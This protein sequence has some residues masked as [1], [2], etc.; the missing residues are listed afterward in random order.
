MYYM[1]YMPEYMARTCSMHGKY[2]Q[3][4]ACD[5]LRTY[6]LWMRLLLLNSECLPVPRESTTAS[7]NVGMGLTMPEARN[8]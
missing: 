4:Q 1:I 6:L 3:E 5:Y 2:F 7:L 8:L